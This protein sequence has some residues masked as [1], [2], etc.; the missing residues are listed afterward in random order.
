M[1]T[2]CFILEN[3]NNTHDTYSTRY[4]KYRYLF[5]A[6]RYVTCHDD[7]WSLPFAPTCNTLGRVRM[8]WNVGEHLQQKGQQYFI[9]ILI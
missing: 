4:K 2:V 6:R 7:L 9:D 8:T 1:L 5:L 3:I